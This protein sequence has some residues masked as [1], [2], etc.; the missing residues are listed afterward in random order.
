MRR[1]PLVTGC[2]PLLLI[3][4]VAR[5]A[6]PDVALREIAAGFLDPVSVTPGPDGRLYVLEQRGTIR[7]VTGAGMADPLSWLDLS[8][9]GLALT[10]AAGERG[11]LGLTFHPA[12][13]ENGWIFLNY[14]SATPACGAG[15]FDTVI[16]RFT[17]TGD[18]PD[19]TTRVD[20]LRIPQPLGNHN[21]GE[22]RFGP[23]GYL[24]VAT[25]DGGGGGDPLDTAQDPGSL[26]GKILRIDVDDPG[27]G[28][29]DR[30][31]GEAHHYG[32]PP[33]NPFLAEGACAELWAI[34]LRNPYRF[35]FDTL[36]G[37]LWIGDVGQRQREELDRVPAGQGGANLGWD[38]REGTLAYDAGGTDPGRPSARCAELPGD[39]FLEPVFDYARA[40][41]RCSV[42]GGFVYRGTI[43]LLRA[44]YVGAD[45]C[46][47]EL[48]VARAGTVPLDAAFQPGAGPSSLAGFGE[49]GAGR[50]FV[51]DRGAGRLL[52]VTARDHVFVGSFEADPPGFALP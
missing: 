21:A 38:C 24:Y 40:D 43:P 52:Q 23:D 48:L 8:D 5:G 36:T 28:P 47:G 33:S 20:V 49:D 44:T 50:L 30:A 46:S 27:A 15:A 14:T 29:V 45:F 19:P 17:V 3:A 34:G 10:C 31:C 16:A 18:G 1:A 6:P 13:A 2:L 42:I 12:F 22:L 4:G 37:D 35:S 32:I 25:G 26:L 41:G 9:E 39:A 11:L 51:V 7:S